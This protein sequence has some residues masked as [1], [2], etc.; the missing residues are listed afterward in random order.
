M[1]LIDT[2]WTSRLAP[3]DSTGVSPYTLVYGKET[4]MQVQLKLNAMT[5]ALNIE[6]IEK[7][8]HI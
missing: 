1:K 8:S 2:L 5:Y 4:K 7:V 6:D 3:K